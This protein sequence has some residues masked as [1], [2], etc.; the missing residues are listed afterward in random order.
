MV[1]DLP[2]MGNYSPEATGGSWKK[3]ATGPAVGARFGGTNRSGWRRWST[4]ATVT[5]CDPPRG[6]TFDVTSGPFPVARW[7]YAIDQTA[8]GCRVTETWVDLRAGWFS[9][10]TGLFTGVSDRASHNREGM[11]RTLERLAEA[12]E[13]TDVS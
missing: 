13:S 7:G 11:Q 12:A 2:G 10:L 6:F 5:E 8:D 1:S 3:G 4:L 9:R